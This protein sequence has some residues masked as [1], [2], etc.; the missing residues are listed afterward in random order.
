M[1]EYTINDNLNLFINGSDAK[2]AYDV[3]NSKALRRPIESSDQ[4]GKPNDSFSE[5]T[6][7]ELPVINIQGVFREIEKL[8]LRRQE[9]KQLSEEVIRIYTEMLQV[10][11]ACVYKYTA[12]GT[13]E[14]LAYS[15]SWS[16]IFKTLKLTEEANGQNNILNPAVLLCRSSINSVGEM[17]RSLKASPFSI[18]T[19]HY[20]SFISLPLVCGGIT[21]G[22]ISLFSTKSKFFI[23]ERIDVIRTIACLVSS[24]YTNIQSRNSLDEE[25]IKQIT[26]QKDNQTLREQ[27]ESH[28]QK[29][30]VCVDADDAYNELEA[31]SYSV[32]HDL[33]APIRAIRSNC[34]WLNKQHA[35]NLDTEGHLLLQQISTSSENM[36]KLLDGLLA[37]SKVVQVDPQQ[38]VIDMTSLVRTVIDELLKYENGSSPLSVVVQPLM[39]AYGDATLMRQVW[40]NLLSN[41]FKYTRYKQN[42]EV[43]IDSQSFNGSVKYCVSDNGIGFDMQY[44]N[45]LFGAFQRLHVAEEFEGTGVGLATVE[46]IVRKYGRQV[47]AEG[48]VDKG[49]KFCFTLPKNIENNK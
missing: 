20:G 19:R 33:R 48:E 7:G 26:L 42:R 43:T 13:L 38:S 39:P 9:L 27:I 10:D 24:L 29:L 5:K 21:V 32:S 17:D 41:A 31:L 3:Q 44:V 12:E 2:H 15:N 28:R 1:I 45:R 40:Y 34:E 36:E 11:G 4:H 25:L 30:N 14:A 22:A 37:F 8:I 6:E 16:N 47:W 49:A 35:A 46:L 18:G 23:S